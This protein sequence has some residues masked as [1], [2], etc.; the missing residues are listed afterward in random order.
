M[1]RVFKVF[2]FWAVFGAVLSAPVFAQ[3]PTGQVI[4]QTPYAGRAYNCN[5][6]WQPYP[7]PETAPVP[8]KGAVTPTAEPLSEE[9]QQYR[10]EELDKYVLREKEVL[11]KK[12]REYAAFSRKKYNI[13]P[14][15]LGDIE[16]YCKLQQTTIEACRQ[17]LFDLEAEL[18]AYEKEFR[19]SK[20]LPPARNDRA[21][22]TL[23]K[24][25]KKQEYKF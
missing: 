13:T 16:T 9:E 2:F 3:A 4:G 18:A 20:G 25:P 8:S 14:R 1:N 6:Q 7:C 24:A 15:S 21:S 23:K 17:K 10:Q 22:Q 5:G 19:K 11:I 12:T